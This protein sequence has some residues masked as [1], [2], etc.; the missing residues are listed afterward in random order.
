[1]TPRA[2]DAQALLAPWVSDGQLAG[3][4][5][6][7]LTLD[8]RAVTRGGLFLALAGDNHHG[9]DFLDQVLAADVS[10]VLWEP[11]ADVD[12]VSV[13]QRC[14]AVGAV[15]VALPGLG[16]QAGAIASR[17]YDDPAR[18]LRLIGVTGTDGKTSVSH[19]IAQ[20]LNTLGTRAAVMGTLGWGHPD[21]LQ[22]S[23]H[24]T[25]DPVTVQA[26]LAALADSGVQT[27]AMEVSSHA[28][29]QH[30]VDAL[31]FDTAVLTYVGRDHL[32]YHGSLEAYQ[33]AKRRLFAWPGLQHQV[34]NLDD[35]VGADLARAAAE[36]LRT[37]TYGRSVNADLRL[38]D[39]QAEANGLSLTLETASGRCQAQ[40]PLLGRFN[41]MNALA[42]L[43]AVVDDQ[44]LQ[45]ALQALGQLRPVPGRMERFVVGHGPLVV[46]DYAHTDGALGAALQS[47]REHTR[48]RLWC[49]FGCGGDRD[50]G[51]RPLMGRVA[52]AHADVVVITSDNPRSEDP[53]QIMAAIR[54]GCTAHPDCHAIESRA[55]AIDFALQ[56]A[57]ADDAVLIAG[58]GHET[59]QM[60]GHIAHPFSDRDC[61]ADCLQRR[62]HG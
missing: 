22:T 18:R 12:A 33:A 48:G 10:V 14:Q 46:I 60:I 30:R 43:G 5:I 44:P 25:A 37:T 62:A 61:V 57:H 20:L 7:G 52:A 28:L 27:V 51:K 40:L 58:K 21:A 42:A 47:L 9:L 49:V 3:R 56:H 45:G 36:G 2:M 1:M 34:L 16:A 41:A 32:D 13:E 53:A 19:Y 55:E 54:A 24:T 8:S 39:V 4:K 35:A 38:H 15:S 6:A 31:S 50:P 17:Y 26:C 29:A 23:T 11:V 59:T